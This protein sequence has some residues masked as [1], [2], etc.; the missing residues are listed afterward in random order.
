MFLNEFFRY[1]VFFKVKK[2]KNY[3]LMIVLFTIKLYSQN[4][5]IVYKMEQIDHRINFKTTVNTYLD[6][7][8]ENSFYEED[9]KNSRNEI[10]DNKDNELHSVNKNIVFRKD[11]KNKTIYYKDHIRFKFFNITDTVGNFNWK[12]EP[13]TKVIL[14]YNCQRATTNFRG[15]NYEVYFTS[16]IPIADGPLKF[17]GLPG[18]ILEVKSNDNLASIKIDVVKIELTS[19]NNNAVSY[20]DTKLENITYAEYKQ[21]YKEKYKESLHKVINEKG[22]TRPMSKGFFEYYVE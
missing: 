2:M 10:L 9:F 20:T 5:S 8:K 17:Y 12:I 16:E 19:N 21:L 22:E 4:Y 3:F 1:L 11:L 14:N 15:R 6:G 18:L 13:E 7:T